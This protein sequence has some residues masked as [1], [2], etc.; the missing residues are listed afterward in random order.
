MLDETVNSH[1]AF[2]WNVIKKPENI[3]SQQINSKDQ[4]STSQNKSITWLSNDNI[5]A[6]SMM[7]IQDAHHERDMFL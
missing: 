2:L 5:S 4:I 1:L 7:C 6:M 3:T